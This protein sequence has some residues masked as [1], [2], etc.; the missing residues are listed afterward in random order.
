MLCLTPLAIAQSHD[1]DDMDPDEPGSEETLNAQLWEYM[2]G[3]PYAE[4]KLHVAAMRGKSGQNEHAENELPTG[5]RLS[6][7]GT[8]VDVGRL[9]CEAVPYAGNLVVLNN[10]Y[11]GVGPDSPE[12][13][14]VDPAAGKVIRTIRLSSLFPSAVTSPDGDLYISGGI[15]KQVYRLNR[16]YETVRTYAVDGYTGGLA[17]ID[18]NHIAVASLVTAAN[19][20]DYAKGNYT[21]GKISILNTATGTIE[22]SVDTGYF[23]YAI[24]LVNGKLYAS[25]LGEDKVLVVDAGT[26]KPIKTLSVGRKPQNMTVSGESLYVANSGSDSIS[27]IDTEKNDVIETFGV[28]NGKTEYGA[29]PVSCAVDAAHNRLFVAL[30]NANQ[31]AV[32][33][34]NSGK[35][36]GA[37]PSGW[38]PTKVLTDSDRLIILNGKGIHDRRPNVNGPQPMANRGGP[39]YV[40]T[41]LKGS[42]EIVPFDNFDSHLPEWTRAADSSSP[43]I[44]I[45]KTAKQQIKHIFYIVRENRTY[46]QVMG[47]LAKANGDASLTLFGREITPNG[48]NIAEQFV[49]LDNY[50]ADGEISVLGHS[51]TTSGYA[52][53]FLEWLGNASYSGRFNGYPFG[54]VPA[55]TS[56]AYLWDALDKKGVDYRIYGE[57]YFLYTRAYDIIRELLGPNSDAAHRFYAQM[58]HLASEMDRGAAFYAFAS[59]W[60]GRADT[61]EAAFALLDNQAFVSAFSNFLCGDETLTPLILIHDDLKAAFASYLAHYPFN[62]RSWDLKFSDLDRAKVWKADFEKQVQSG[63]VA[64]LHYLWLPNDHTGGT[65]KQYLP[66]DQLVAENDAALG[67]ILETISHSPIWKQS[68]ILVTED[69]AQNGPDHIDATRTVALAAGPNV[70]RGMVISD[71]FDQLSLLRTIG[72]LLGVPPLSQNDALAAPMFS[73]FAAKGR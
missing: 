59:P 62:Y 64:A 67:Y 52:S 61:P 8:Q 68:L 18:S 6:P 58:M 19:I 43:R 65:S 28:K 3:T 45:D 55:A 15:S 22:Q 12:V 38:Y 17:V 20:N 2:K 7:A 9:P 57:N 60:Y 70:K 25:L 23:P 31:I 37:I 1:A 71:R 14:I 35:R 69:D 44:G 49:T 42:V 53:P 30:A 4:A 46:D 40:L 39:D 51:F 63:K 10:G 41:L 11:Y 54:M 48:H 73:I 36:L 47:D 24:A 72:L 13:S 32:L 27:V 66:P 56:P 33:D 5:W 21:T 26:L 34:L 29:A 50:F 16:N